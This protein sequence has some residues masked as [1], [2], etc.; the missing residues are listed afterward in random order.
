MARLIP[1]QLPEQ[2]SERMLVEALCDQLDDAFTLF[3]NVDYLRGAD[4]ANGEV[5]VL[6]AHH[7]LGLCFIE[8]K[9]KGVTCEADGAWLRQDGRRPPEPLRRSP[10]SQVQR[11]AEQIRAAI[12]PVL[13][14]TI[15]HA[16]ATWNEYAWCWMLA[17][18]KTRVGEHIHLPLDLPREVVIDA[19]DL[20]NAG[21]RVHATMLKASQRARRDPNEPTA[22]ARALE[23]AI[24]PRLHLV[25][26][27][28]GQIELSKRRVVRLDAR[29]RTIVEC[30]D[31]NDRF[32]VHGPA[33]TGKSLLAL[34]TAR[35]WA[36]RRGRHVLLVCFNKMLRARLE[37]AVAA[38]PLQRGS[39]TVTHFH[40]LV[41]DALEALGR[42]SELPAPGASA[43]A[44]RVFWEQ[45]APPAI[46]DAV[47]Q[48]LLPLVDA[49]VVDEAQDLAADWWVYLSMVLRDPDEGPLAAFYDPAQAVFGR[50]CAVPDTLF[51]LRLRENY[52]NPRAVVETLARIANTELRAHPDAEEGE[53][54]RVY[55]GL[56]A[57][58]VARKLD[59]LV[60]QA[61][62]A[63]LRPDELVVLGPRRR[64]NSSLADV[65]MLGGVPITDDLAEQ[66]GHVLY[67]TVPGFK[68]LD[69]PVVFLIDIDAANPRC[70]A[71]V[72]YVGAS[73]ATHALHVFTRGAGW[74]G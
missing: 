64:A 56:S 55:P 14:S 27:L 40:G 51:T 35:R 47:E 5:D 23:A 18:P 3:V 17:F 52:R 43:D 13:A 25:P 58:K 33:G 66:P 49:L 53:P 4:L 29:Q 50:P 60:A 8:C 36:E 12:D 63:G 67:A 39:V 26:D 15:T 44:M 42:D 68:G 11:H 73:R 48:G 6:V 24:H 21:D 30:V 45:T 41:F 69:A 1:N 7:R 37:H 20:A 22:W 70:D 2:P 62:R 46:G 71:G 61:L 28:G 34:E 19:S 74:D 72:R 65:E 54:V 57:A 31:D 38:W 59:E 32:R 16:G 9:G 10:M